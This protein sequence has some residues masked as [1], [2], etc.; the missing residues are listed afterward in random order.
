[1]HA[2]DRRRQHIRPHTAAQGSGGGAPGG[3]ALSRVCRPV[4]LQADRWRR[5]VLRR[6]PVRMSA[7]GLLFVSACCWDAQTA[8]AWC[9]TMWHDMS[10]VSE[11][12]L[13]LCLR[14]SMGCRT[15]GA[16]SARVWT[17]RTRLA[18]R[19]SSPASPTPHGTTPR[20]DGPPQSSSFMS[21]DTHS[22]RLPGWT[23]LQKQSCGRQCETRGS[24]S[25]AL[26]CML[27]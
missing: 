11:L 2:L 8:Y 20:C 1:M 17:L 13:P 19:W 26:P 7:R 9:I 24:V 10:I 23:C 25:H 15:A 5:C 22:R 21:T 4:P 14:S 18:V 3:G 6:V 12:P 27:R 16:R